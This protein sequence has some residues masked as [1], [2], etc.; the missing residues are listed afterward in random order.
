MKSIYQFVIGIFEALAEARRM[1][2]QHLIKN[3][4]NNYL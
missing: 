1:Q 4:L 2:A 3:R